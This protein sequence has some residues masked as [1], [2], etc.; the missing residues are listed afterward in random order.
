[1]PEIHDC[2]YKHP[3]VSFLSLRKNFLKVDTEQAQLLTALKSFT[4]FHQRNGN[5]YFDGSSSSVKSSS[6]CRNV[7]ILKKIIKL[8]GCQNVHTTQSL[9]DMLHIVV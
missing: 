6:S 8:W 9:K 4:S 1:M 2:N 7:W 3:A 5:S